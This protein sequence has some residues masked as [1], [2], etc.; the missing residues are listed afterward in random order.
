MLN[1]P[2]H[3][4]KPLVRRYHHF[5]IIRNLVDWLTHLTY[6]GRPMI[7]RYHPFIIVRNLVERLTHLNYRGKR[8]IRRY[9]PVQIV[10][11]FLDRAT[12]HAGERP[13]VR[14]YHPILIARGLL[15]GTYRLAQTVI[16]RVTLRNH[17]S[18]AR[19]FWPDATRTE[20]ILLAL[21]MAVL[22]FHHYLLA[23]ICSHAHVARRVRRRRRP[24]RRG[25]VLHVT[26]SFDLGG[27]QT[28][29][30]NLC[31][32]GGASRLKHEA[33]EIFPESNF[34]FRQGARIEPARYGGD[35]CI[36][37][38]LRR[39]TTYP[40]TRSS[41][42]IQIYK[43]TRDMA[44][45]D[46]EIVVGWGHELCMLTFV[47]AT[48]ARVPHIVF[49]IRTFNPDY[50]WMD[51][52]MGRLARIA[53]RR[54]QPLV[55][56]VIVNSTVLQA[57]YAAW[58]G[59]ERSLIDVCPNGIDPPPI[60]PHEARRRRG[61]IRQRFLI[62]DDTLVIVHVGRFSA[63][64]GQLS[65]MRA[66]VELLRRF[67]DRSFVWILCGDGPT[68]SGVQDF[69]ESH[70][71]R[72]VVFA[73]RTNDVSMFL[74]AADIFVMPSDFEG[75]PN[76]MMEALAHGVPCVSTDR[77]GAIDIARDSIEALYYEPRDVHRLVDRLTFLFDHADERCR[78]GKSG[79]M[80]MRE[81]SVARFIDRFESLLNGGVVDDAVV[82]ST[83][84]SPSLP[85][86]GGRVAS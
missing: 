74:S 25:F 84:A 38:A 79:Q 29:I 31:H 64:K 71:M 65:L 10:R 26:C 16:A 59:I 62:S 2:T 85:P 32:E 52:R 78:L 67:P 82:P 50:G 47:A 45:V 23:G 68:M 53:H 73:G 20:I 18:N 66:N 80:R 3:R 58:L 60:D 51:V 83:I 15:A 21:W 57:D 33:V 76:A 63:E 77:S 35:G 4:S 37:R 55:S 56:K 28:Q 48:I 17:R 8:V 24:G 27:T 41:Q 44:V 12:S 40:G 11:N 61:A 75:M 70:G 30:K 49:C 81:F 19:A 46:P 42:I 43:L 39:L 7:R 22:R 69:V 6:R 36:G 13:V 54:M 9:H 5:I 14:R 34:L 72:N 1:S 86:S